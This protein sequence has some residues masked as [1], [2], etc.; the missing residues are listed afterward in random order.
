QAEMCSLPG[1]LLL[2]LTGATS[3]EEPWI[4][5]SP[6]ELWLSPGETA[7]LNCNI[8]GSTDRANWYRE[9]PDGSLEWIYWSAAAS[10]P[11]GRYSGT[12]KELGFFSL[13]ISDV[14]LVTGE[15]GSVWRCWGHP[16][17]H[18]WGTGFSLSLSDASEP[19][20]SILVPVDTEEPSD[21]VSLLCHLPGSWNLTWVSAERWDGAMNCTA[22]ERGTGRIVSE[23][24]G[25]GELEQPPPGHRGLCSVLG[26]CLQGPQ[27]RFFQP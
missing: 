16:W 27:A 13:N 9:K 20:L 12:V 6:A 23:T 19:K 1:V 14:L 15:S 24:T 17:G 21:F 2:L 18:P 26:L 5:Q 4:Q 7:E 11:E 22:T 25:T 3:A 10:K 8:S